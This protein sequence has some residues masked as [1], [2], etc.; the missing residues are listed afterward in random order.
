MITTQIMKCPY[1]QK[2][3]YW[4]DSQGNENPTRPFCSQRC[5]MIDLGTWADEGYRLSEP[6][7]DDLV[8]FDSFDKSPENEEHGYIN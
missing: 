8:N 2:E 4:R 1:C 6:G 3:T 5:Q 7:H